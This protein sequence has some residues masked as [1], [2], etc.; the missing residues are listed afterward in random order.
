MLY[1]DW[2][3]IGD[4]TLGFYGLAKMNGSLENG[5]MVWTTE[6]VALKSITRLHDLPTDLN[7]LMETAKTQIGCSNIWMRQWGAPD[8]E[9]DNPDEGEMVFES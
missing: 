8:V 2:I 5:Q 4:V 9:S 3:T 7:K 6:N 1:I